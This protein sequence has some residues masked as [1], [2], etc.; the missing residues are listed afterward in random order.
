LG[1]GLGLVVS[2]AALA[3]LGSFA[4][5]PLYAYGIGYVIIDV[6]WVLAFALYRSRSSHRK[7]AAQATGQ[8]KGETEEKQESG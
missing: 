8:Q 4:P 6:V 2:I 3:I 7:S 5:I 1:F